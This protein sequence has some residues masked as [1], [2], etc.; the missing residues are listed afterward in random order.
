MLADL[1]LLSLAVWEPWKAGLAS[2]LMGVGVGVD[3]GIETIST[4]TSTSPDAGVLFEDDVDWSSQISPLPSP[5]RP[6]H[7][8]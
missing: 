6:H 8:E 5:A 3:M 2:W 4:S 1:S 7:D